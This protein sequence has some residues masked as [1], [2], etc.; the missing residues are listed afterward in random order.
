MHTIPGAQG[1]AILLAAPS[2]RQRLLGPR[3][4]GESPASDVLLDLRPQLFSLD[5]TR[6]FDLGLLLLLDRQQ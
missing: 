4:P 2:P 6:A 3:L 1:H 5:P